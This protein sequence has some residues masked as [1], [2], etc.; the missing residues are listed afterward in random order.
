MTIFVANF[1]KETEESDLKELF[2]EYG[3]VRYVEIRRDWV[4]GEPLGYAFVEMPRASEAEHAISGLDGRS[5]RGR[6]LK[7]NEKQERLRKY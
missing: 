7:V 3:T 6:R 5:W 2:E 4:T 1:N